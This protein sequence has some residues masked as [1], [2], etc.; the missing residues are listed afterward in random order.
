MHMKQSN[1]FGMCRFHVLMPCSVEV[2]Y[3][4]GSWPFYPL[5]EELLVRAPVLIPRPET[6]EL[7]DRTESRP[8]KK[9]L[10]DAARS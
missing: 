4:L 9:C 2:Q 3:I 8:G 5:P 6:E 1:L 7:V 10:I